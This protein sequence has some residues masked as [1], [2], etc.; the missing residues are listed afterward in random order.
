MGLLIS[1]SM[2]VF[3]VLEYIRE[4]ATTTSI[5]TKYNGASPSSQFLL[6]VCCGS[7]RFL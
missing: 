2:A 1:L 7:F 5:L 3:V 4:L 6:T